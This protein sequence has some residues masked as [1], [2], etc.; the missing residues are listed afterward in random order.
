MLEDDQQEAQMLV[1][2]LVFCVKNPELPL[3]KAGFCI[4]E[5]QPRGASK[6][7]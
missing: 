6:S 1:R 3:K 5:D 7:R 2:T 4:E